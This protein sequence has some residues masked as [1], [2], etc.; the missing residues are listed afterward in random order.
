MIY[1]RFVVCGDSYSEGMTD[2]I[3]DGQFRGWADR[4]ADGLA[5][6]SPTFTLSLIHI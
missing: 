6:K 1:N 3:V 5:A 2:D 4:V